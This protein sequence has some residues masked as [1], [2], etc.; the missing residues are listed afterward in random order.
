MP[1]SG[2]VEEHLSLAHELA[3][4]RQRGVRR[5]DG[6][7]GEEALNLPG[8][9]KLL[10]GSPWWEVAP[11]SEALRRM[12]HSATGYVARVEGSELS[13]RIV[14]MFG[15]DDSLRLYTPRQLMP[16][17][18]V[19]LSHLERRPDEKSSSW[20]S[21]ERTWREHAYYLLIDA[22]KQGEQRGWI[23]ASAPLEKPTVFDLP[24][25]PSLLVGRHKEI[26]AIAHPPERSSWIISGPAGVGKTALALAAA[27]EMVTDYPDGAIFLDF[28]AYGVGEPVSLET[29]LTQFLIRLGYDAASLSNDVL[30]LKSSYRSEMRSRRILV[31]ADN[32]PNSEVAAALHVEGEGLLLATSRRIL[33]EAAAVRGVSA[34]NLTELDP[35]SSAELLGRMAGERR[36]QDDPE[37]L[38]AICRACGHLPLALALVGARLALRPKRPLSDVLRTLRAAGTGTLDE[39]PIGSDVTVAIV[40]KWSI[41]SLNRRLRSLL[42]GLA[43]LPYQLIETDHAIRMGFAVRD[44]EGLLAENLLR[45]E[46]DRLVAFHDLIRMLLQSDL[47]ARERDAAFDEKMASVLAEQ[48]DWH[49]A[50]VK[51]QVFRIL[52]WRRLEHLADRKAFREAK[53]DLFNVEQPQVGFRGIQMLQLALMSASVGEYRRALSEIE[54]GLLYSVTTRTFEICGAYLDAGFERVLPRLVSGVSDDEAHELTAPLVNI[55]ADLAAAAYLFTSRSGWRSRMQPVNERIVF[56]CEWLEVDDDLDPEAHRKFLFI[57]KSASDFYDQVRWLGEGPSFGA[58]PLT[59]DE[60]KLDEIARSNAEVEYVAQ[61]AI[62]VGRDD[63]GLPLLEELHRRHRDEVARGIDATQRWGVEPAL[64]RLAAMLEASGRTSDARQ[65][66]LDVYKSYDERGDF[67]GHLIQLRE[68]IDRLA[69][70]IA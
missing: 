57:D 35:E 61:Q 21:R 39:G 13:D 15:L 40:L 10:V 64:I 56:W 42:F 37:S 53:P 62:L 24:A 36:G 26:A 69:T 6:G 41:D 2:R 44:V 43:L 67:Q 46:S 60:A 8:L 19:G 48:R 25:R 31:V 14:T 17:A 11:R 66:L 27:Y 3:R 12:L 23:D 51:D 52:T 18:L 65:T 59:D 49:L 45:E 47:L 68:W 58:G 63:L 38:K 70:A 16:R 20:E 55:V 30:V 54:V 7:D 5:V 1:E 29:C 22:F 9:E 50:Y 4:V 33:L 28:N 34:V 32:I